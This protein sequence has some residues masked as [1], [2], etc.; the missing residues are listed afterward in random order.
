LK[1]CRR[2]N[3]RDGIRRLDPEVAAQPRPSIGAVALLP[4]APALGAQCRRT[5]F[6]RGRCTLAPGF[7]AAPTKE[8]CM[9]TIILIVLVVLA[10]GGFGHTGYRRRWYGGYDRPQPVSGGW[11]GG[12]LGLI[13]L[14][15]VLFLLFGGGG[16]YMGNPHP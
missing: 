12:G 15:I 6:D 16:H 5:A 8:A 1:H 4:A 14:I 7:V 9:F 3:Q 10:L 2:L 11:F 13:L